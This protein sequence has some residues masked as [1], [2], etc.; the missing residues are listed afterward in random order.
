MDTSEQFWTRIEKGQNGIMRGELGWVRKWRLGL[1]MRSQ[2]WE[3]MSLDGLGA[4]EVKFEKD[5]RKTCS[6]LYRISA[7]LRGNPRRGD[8]L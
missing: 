1:G 6:C 8:R 3:K 5:R 7:K 4:K 2:E